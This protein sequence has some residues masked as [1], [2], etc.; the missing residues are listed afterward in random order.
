MPGRGVPPNAEALQIVIDAANG[1]APDGFWCFPWYPRSHLTFSDT[2]AAV[3]Y[4]LWTSS[5]LFF[6]S[7][8]DADMAKVSVRCWTGSPTPPASQPEMAK[9][10]LKGCMVN[11]DAAFS[12]HLLKV[13]AA[14]AVFAGPARAKTDQLTSR[15]AAT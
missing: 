11:D 1:G 9:V 15:S 7:T 3:R 12:H 14:E 4:R 10:E 13:T 5:A 2:L 6:P 8:D